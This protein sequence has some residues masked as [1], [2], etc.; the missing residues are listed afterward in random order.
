MPAF[1]ELL[2]LRH[3]ETEWNL[4][5]RM[6]G[7]LDSPLTD[8]GRQQ[9]RAQNAVL[10]SLDLSGF[11]WFA[12]PQPRALLTARIVAKG[13]R[14]PIAQDPRLREIGMGDWT[15]QQRRAIVAQF[16]HLFDG[17][18]PLAF[19]DHAPAGEGLAALTAR[20][21]AFLDDLDRPS[22][23]ITH[24]ITSRVL[25]CLAL[26]LPTGAFGALDGGQGIVYR[27]APEG[28]SKLTPAGTE[29]QPIPQD[30]A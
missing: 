25:R 17:P 30:F 3:G 13:N 14:A 8:R 7:A 9:A 24:G 10:R 12:S 27:V 20:A 11:G 5:G 19:Y 1:P 23:I 16:P 15:G 2:I 6:Q 21:R 28:Y 4:E 22:V 18:N 26:G 29:P